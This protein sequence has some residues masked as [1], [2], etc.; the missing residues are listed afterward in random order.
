[1]ISWV[2]AAD[3][4]SQLM[5]LVHEEMSQFFDVV[6]E[7]EFKEVVEKYPNSRWVVS[8]VKVSRI[9]HGA[10]HMEHGEGGYERFQTYEYFMTQSN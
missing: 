3:Q 4:E 6:N 7:K 10:Q 9:F 1:M 5:K 2:G 8:A